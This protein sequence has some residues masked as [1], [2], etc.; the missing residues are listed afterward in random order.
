[1]FDNSAIPK[2]FEFYAIFTDR[3]YCRHKGWRRGIRSGDEHINIVDI[4]DTI[5]DVMAT[6]TKGIA[7]KRKR[8]AIER[9]LDEW[10]SEDPDREQLLDDIVHGRAGFS[11]RTMDWLVTN[12][13]ARKPVVYEHPEKPGSIVDV[14]G[15]YKDVLRCFHKSGFDSFKR[16]GATPAEAE[17]RQRNFFRW[18]MTN[19]VVDYVKK[20]ARVIEEDMAEVR[21]RQKTPTTSPSKKKRKTRET[22]TPTLSAA[23]VIISAN[24]AVHDIP[25]FA[26]KLV[27]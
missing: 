23:G 17:L 10:Y 4:H 16:K 26:G 3:R 11:L 8:E 9:S 7:N 20:N 13:A 6:S 1:M 18:A 12:Y 24:S 15:M 21:K 22:A 2:L 5:G 25:N 19:G 27:W 14:N